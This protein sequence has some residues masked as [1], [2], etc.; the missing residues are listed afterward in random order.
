MGGPGLS[1]PSPEET[2][3]AGGQ[4]SIALLHHGFARQLKPLLA[5]MRAAGSGAMPAPTVGGGEKDGKDGKG[6]KE[7]AGGGDNGGSNGGAS[8][9]PPLG[10][11][12]S[13]GGGGTGGLAERALLQPA[14]VN[15]PAVRVRMCIFVDG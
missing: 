1:S 10:S 15:D 8:P 4:P 5:E 13:S 6:T 12:S 3:T 7:G 14:M 11:D 9:P 2:T